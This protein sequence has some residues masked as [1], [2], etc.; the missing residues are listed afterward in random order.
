M[1]RSFNTPRNPRL[2][3]HLAC[4]ATERVQGMYKVNRNAL[5]RIVGDQELPSI[6]STV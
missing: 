2:S 4:L 5:Q 3:R 1:P 6:E